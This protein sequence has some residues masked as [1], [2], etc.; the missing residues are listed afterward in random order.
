MKFTQ[1]LLASSVAALAEAT[2]I[3]L[4]QEEADGE[5]VDVVDE[6]TGVCGAMCKY[7]NDCRDYIRGEV[8]S[9]V[10]TQLKEILDAN[11]VTKG[12]D[13]EGIA[14]PFDSIRALECHLRAEF[15]YQM[16]PPIDWVVFETAALDFD[17]C[18]AE[19]GVGGVKPEFDEQCADD[20]VLKME[21]IENELDK[22]A[23]EAEFYRFLIDTAKPY[24]DGNGTEHEK[25]KKKKGHGGKGGGKGGNK[26]GKHEYQDDLSLA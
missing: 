22:A 3:R 16:E 10:N 18:A 2:M 20:E 12:D 17:V 26:G 25:C 13:T 8:K 4:R 24:L 11:E 21:M 1:I 23:D 15:E 7:Y 14:I 5:A 19:L 6:E 9:N